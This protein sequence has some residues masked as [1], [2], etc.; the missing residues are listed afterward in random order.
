MRSKVSRRRFMRIVAGTAS[1]GFAGR[2]FADDFPTATWRGLVMGNLAS[3]E[4]RHSDP[5]RAAVL[6]DRARAEMQRLESIMSL[7]RPDSALSVLNSK[8]ILRNPPLDLVRILSEAQRFGALSRGRFDVTVQP[9]WTLYAEHFSKPDRDPAGPPADLVQQVAERVDYRA[10]EVEPDMI[11]FGLAEMQV[12]LNGIAQGYITDRISELFANEGLDHALVD[13]GEIRAV[14]DRDV[15][16]A[17]NAGIEDPFD[18]KEILAEVQLAGNALAT[19]GGYGFKF[20]PAGTIHH[21]FDPAT[22]TSPHRYA[23]VS[24][25]AADA[26]T[27]DALATAANLLAP[28]AILEILRQSGAQRVM[29]VDAE[30]GKRWLTA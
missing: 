20:D 12:T 13:L 22:G 27:A 8:G 30:G 26:T 25:V 23:S 1:C 19:S 29:L 3:I 16:R 21:I 10:I 9:L 28:D 6:L 4:I 2:A 15:S 18:R 7:Y 11:R 14:G 17:W 5:A 24:V